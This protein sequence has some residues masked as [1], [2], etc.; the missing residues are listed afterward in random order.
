MTTM[1]YPSQGRTYSPPPKGVAVVLPCGSRALS[2][3]RGRHAD[4]SGIASL[5]RLSFPR[6]E[7]ANTARKRKCY[8]LQKDLLTNRLLIFDTAR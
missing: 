5:F 4:P 3:G 1:S 2:E 7:R 8:D 6:W